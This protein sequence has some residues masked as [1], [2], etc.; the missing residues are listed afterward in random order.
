M[1][2]PIGTRLRLID[3]TIMSANY[4]AIAVV[5]GHGTGERIVVKWIEGQNNQSDGK[6]Y[7]NRFEAIDPRVV[8]D[9][10]IA[11]LQAQRAALDEIYVGDTVKTTKNNTATVMSIVGEEAWVRTKRG[12]NIISKLTDLKKVY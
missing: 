11:E 2:Y 7:V 4:G 10:Q 9:A 8:L 3:T 1:K 5:T 6:Y 12:Q